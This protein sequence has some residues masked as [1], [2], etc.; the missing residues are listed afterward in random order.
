MDVKVEYRN[1]KMDVVSEK[2]YPL[3]IY[4][5]MIEADLLRLITDIEDLCYEVNGNR[6]KDEWSDETWAAFC[7]IKHKLLD[8][9]GEIGRLPDNLVETPP[10]QP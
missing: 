9:A 6:V 2:T 10:C 4:T 7:K 8:K 3:A 1:A 5:G